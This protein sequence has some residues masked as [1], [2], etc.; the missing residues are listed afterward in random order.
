MHLLWANIFTLPKMSSMREMNAVIWKWSNSSW[1]NPST[2]S[3]LWMFSSWWPVYVPY[4]TENKCNS[5]E[6]SN[7]SRISDSA[8][9]FLEFFIHTLKYPIKDL[10]FP[11]CKCN[12]FILDFLS[13]FFLLIILSL[14]YW[15]RSNHPLCPGL[16]GLVPKNGHW[17]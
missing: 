7:Y 10:C 15:F 12:R 3:P 2:G 14:S 17:H 4:L 1:T 11:F 6:K 16:K 13:A 9:I 8:W 5:M